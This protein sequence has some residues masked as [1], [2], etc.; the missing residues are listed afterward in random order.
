MLGDVPLIQFLR[1]Q[2]SQK[3]NA[4]E[5]L[6]FQSREM[7]RTCQNQQAKLRDWDVEHVLSNKVRENEGGGSDVKAALTMEVVEAEDTFGDLFAGGS[8][9]LPEATAQNASSSGL[10]IK[11]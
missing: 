2:L 1:E 6:Q 9:L 7:E 11:E 8:L 4:M 10:G 3:D 5:E